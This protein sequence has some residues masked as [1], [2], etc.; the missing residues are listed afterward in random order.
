MQNR[1]LTDFIVLIKSKT[2]VNSILST[3][4][5]RILSEQIKFKVSSKKMV[6]AGEKN[7][8]GNM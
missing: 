7:G 1:E 8:T 3:P 5:Y 2:V 4:L 6:V